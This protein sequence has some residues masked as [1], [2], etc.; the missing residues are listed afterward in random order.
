MAPGEAGGQATARD[1]VNEQLRNLLPNLELGAF[2]E[3][4]AGQHI[5]QHGST[6]VDVRV[7]QVG[8]SVA[9]RSSAPVA[10]GTRL[11]PDL[12][13]FLLEKNA[14]IPFGAFGVDSR[15]TVVFAHTI[16]ASSSMDLAELSASVRSVLL[17]ADE[18]DDR[19]VERWGG[20][21]FKH[22]MI[23]QVLPS[24]ILRRL[25]RKQRDD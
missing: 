7:V 13:R 17:T 4:G 9:V 5:C 25:R 11:Q 18:F 3:V 2:K 14:S 6:L 10:V 15:G 23:E 19:I 1:N 12:L 24:E 8:D 22:A 20:K 21:T 16:L